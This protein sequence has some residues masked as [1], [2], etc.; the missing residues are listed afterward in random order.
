MSGMQWKK[1]IGCYVAVY[2]IYW[3]GDSIIYTL[4]L[5]YPINN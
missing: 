4:M 1:V 2:I 5:V 3:D